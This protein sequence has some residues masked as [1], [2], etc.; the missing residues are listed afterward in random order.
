MTVPL[1]RIRNALDAK[2]AKSLYNF[3]VLS[4][5]NNRRNHCISLLFCHRKILLLVSLFNKV[6]GLQAFKFFK[7]R[8]LNNICERLLRKMF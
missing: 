1:S 4:Q 7:T 6:A 8:I 3:F 2:Q 5:K